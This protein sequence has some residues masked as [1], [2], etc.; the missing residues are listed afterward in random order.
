M[1]AGKLDKR[2]VFE[3]PSNVKGAMGGSTTTWAT[4]CTV[5]GGIH[6]I[7]G[8]ETLSADMID[9][10]ITAKCFIRY[11]AGITPDMRISHD[12]KLW[13]IHAVINKDLANKYLE[14]LISEGL[15]DG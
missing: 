1:R 12:G 15:N 14:I 5:W 4:F 6:P 13:N 2:L 9:T 11:K 3:Q 8:R 7:S 10:E